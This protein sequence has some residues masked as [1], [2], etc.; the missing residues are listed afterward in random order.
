MFCKNGNEVIAFD[1]DP[2]ALSKF[3]HLE[4]I[5][6]FYGNIL[7][8]PTLTE[9]LADTDIVVH[10]AAMKHV[11]Y[12]EERPWK[13]CQHNVLGIMNVVR[14]AEQHDVE[15]V[16]I[17]TDKAVSPT[18]VM[19]ATKLIAEHIVSHSE[20]NASNVRLGN[21]LNSRGSF[22]RLFHDL[23][24]NNR[25]LPVTDRGMTRFV[26]PRAKIRKFVSKAVHDDDE[27]TTIVPKL[28]SVRVGTVADVISDRYEVGI[29]E[30]GRRRG[31]KKHELLINREEGHR[32]IERDD[33]Y[34]VGN[35]DGDVEPVTSDEFVLSRSETRELV[36]AD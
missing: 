20:V 12:A 3:G 16:N 30:V 1:R 8:K 14:E 9:A 22:V 24:R 15:V 10:T 18:G 4:N 17:S 29:N 35:Y 6:V 13:S 11:P 27:A 33:Y 25:D 19:G 31:E 34:V 7:D 5:E 2:A 26:T 21:V 28:S 36:L 32:T 23:G